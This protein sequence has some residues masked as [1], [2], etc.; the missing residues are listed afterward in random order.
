MST[1]EVLPPGVGRVPKWW[2]EITPHYMLDEEDEEARRLAE[3]QMAFYYM[4]LAAADDAGIIMPDGTPKLGLDLKPMVWTPITPWNGRTA[5]E[6]EAGG[7]G[8]MGPGGRNFK[9]GHPV[10]DPKLFG[11]LESDPD[12]QAY[13]T[14]VKLP[15][16]YFEKMFEIATTDPAGGIDGILNNLKQTDYGRYGRQAEK[17]NFKPDW[18]KKK[19]RSTETGANIRQGQYNDSPN[20]HIRRRVQCLEKAPKIPL[21]LD[22]VDAEEETA[23]IAY[24]VEHIQVKI[25]QISYEQKGSSATAKEKQKKM[26]RKVR[27]VRKKDPNSAEA[28]PSATTEQKRYEHS[29]NYH[30]NKPNISEQDKKLKE[31]QEKLKRLQELQRQLKEQQEQEDLH[32]KQQQEAERLK[33][34]HPQHPQQQD[35]QEQHQQRQQHPQQQLLHLQQQQQQQEPVPDYDEESYEEEIIEEMVDDYSEESYEEEIIEYD[36]EDDNAELTDLQAI[37][38]AKQ[39]ELQRLQAQL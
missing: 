9:P 10:V 13:L 24:P 6:G 37:L 36:D 32:R 33:Q 11:I 7:S 2:I 39:A 29:D 23:T 5:K 22:Q 8:G 16:G 3:D 21:T 35:Q 25:Q 14:G 31:Q 15:P 17:P 19:L 27:K 34:Q 1:M 28:E 38:V 4:Q 26:V 18:A 30:N 20:K 12:Y